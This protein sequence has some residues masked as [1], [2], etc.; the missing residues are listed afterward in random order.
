[1]AAIW[2][3]SLKLPDTLKSE[4]DLSTKFLNLSNQATDRQISCF[5]RIGEKYF[6]HCVADCISC[7]KKGLERI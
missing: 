5:V 1:M 6:P 4:I 3:P 7:E 2:N